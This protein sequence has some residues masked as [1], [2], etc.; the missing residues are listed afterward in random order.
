VNAGERAGILAV[1]TNTL[2]LFMVTALSVV[3][4]PELAIRIDA[5]IGGRDGSGSSLSYF[6]DLYVLPGALVFLALSGVAFALAARRGRTALLVVAG[7]AWCVL[8]AGLVGSVE[9]YYRAVRAASEL[10]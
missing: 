10:R 9:W 1:T 7:V 4:Y 5:L 3:T 2:A 8:L 6:R